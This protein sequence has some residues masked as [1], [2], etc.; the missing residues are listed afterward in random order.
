MC[1]RLRYQGT[2]PMP[3]LSRNFKDIVSM[4]SIKSWISFAPKDVNSS[5]E[6]YWQMCY[7]R[8]LDSSSCLSWGVFSG[9]V[10][11]PWGVE[12]I[13]N[14]TTNTGFLKP[15]IIK[16]R[17]FA[18]MATECKRQ[19]YSWLNS[20]ASLLSSVQHDR[21]SKQNPHMLATYVEAMYDCIYR[22]C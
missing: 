6:L 9:E 4:S 3:N 12:Q 20:A 11:I 14:G 5:C 19:D 21:R 13:P 2:M 15:N 18:R 1:L 22:H 8:C 10:G 7:W 16:W 17:Y